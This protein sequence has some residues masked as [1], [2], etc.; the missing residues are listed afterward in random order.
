MTVRLNIF[1]AYLH[2]HASSK[3]LVDRGTNT[4][5]GL[6]PDSASRHLSSFC[7]QCA[8][9]RFQ[10]MSI[11]KVAS[12]GCSSYDIRFHLHTTCVMPMMSH[13]PASITCCRHCWRSVRGGEK[14]GSGVLV[15]RDLFEN[16]LDSSLGAE[17][18]SHGADG[19]LR[20][21]KS[22]SSEINSHNEEIFALSLSTSE[23]SDTCKPDST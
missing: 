17:Q 20:G 15:T 12:M 18:L 21:D 2:L 11:A 13:S 5:K 4:A 19:R 3:I 23:A 8:V 22:Y 9:R 1:C 7:L 10:M 6:N 16:S 14:H